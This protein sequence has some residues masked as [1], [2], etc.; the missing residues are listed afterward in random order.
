MATARVSPTPRDARVGRGLLNSGTPMPTSA[1]HARNS[2]TFASGRSVARTAGTTSTTSRVDPVASPA[3][4]EAV[5][6][7]WPSAAVGVTLKETVASAPGESAPSAPEPSTVHV[8]GA[9]SATV[10]PSQATSPPLRTWATTSKGC[11]EP[12]D[13]RRSVVR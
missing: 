9:V 13:R 10:A 5:R 1:A 4:S 2:S 12:A 6:N 11:H 8:D 3:C 7:F